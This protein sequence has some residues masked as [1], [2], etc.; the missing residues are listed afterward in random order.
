MCDAP[1]PAVEGLTTGN[2]NSL[3]T[4]LVDGMKGLELQCTKFRVM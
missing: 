3:S 2:G 4:E 1:L